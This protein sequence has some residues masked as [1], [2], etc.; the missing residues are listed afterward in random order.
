MLKAAYMWLSGKVALCA[1]RSWL[2]HWLLPRP[3]VLLGHLLDAG[4]PP[5]AKHSTLVVYLDSEEDRARFHRAL[6]YAIDMALRDTDAA[7][8]D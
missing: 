8:R 6:C 2:W 4:Y 5:D 3:D 7:G 1:L